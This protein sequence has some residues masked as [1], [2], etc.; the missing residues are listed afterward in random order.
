[1]RSSCFWVCE[2][3][4]GSVF[5]EKSSQIACKQHLKLR[6]NLVLR[7]IFVHRRGAPRP[8][9]CVSFS[10]EARSA[11]CLVKKRVFS[12][13]P[14]PR[15]AHAPPGGPQITPGSTIFLVFSNGFCDFAEKPSQLSSKMP[16]GGPAGAHPSKKGRQ[17][18]Q[19]GGSE[20]NLLHS[21]VECPFS[22]QL[23]RKRPFRARVVKAKVVLH[24]KIDRF[25]HT[26]DQNW[27]FRTSF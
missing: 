10:N 8:F 26:P 4:C 1:M 18:R 14:S 2:H 24:G 23:L 6:A 27:P 5:C 3:F 7:R 9:L 16:I 13:F 19:N 20:K 11:F 25:G 15:V 17:S 12:T 22:I 21:A